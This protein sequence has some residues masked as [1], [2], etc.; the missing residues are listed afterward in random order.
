MEKN[1]INYGITGTRAFGPVSE[2]SDL[3]LVITL[4]D[5]ITL[6]EYLA[7]HDIDI[8]KLPESEEY[9]DGKTSCYYFSLGGILINIIV[10]K[11]KEEYMDWKRRTEAMR[12]LPPIYDRELRMAKFNSL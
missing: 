6:L 11:N 4:H 7:E 9:N 3:D 8:A 12:K 10:A 5:S 1:T 2:D